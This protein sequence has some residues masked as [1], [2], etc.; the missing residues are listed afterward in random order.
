MSRRVLFLINSL[1]DGG[2]QVQLG[3]IA[4]GL[5]Q[6]GW[7]A[8][9]LSLLTPGSGDAIFQAA[10]IPVRVLGVRRGL[11]APYALRDTIRWI[12]PHR[13]CVLV[14]LL[15]QAH[16]IGR[17]A[18]AIAR[19]PVIS[20]IRNESLGGPFRH[21]LMRLT[22]ALDA[23]TTVN[24]AAAG[25]SLVGRGVAPDGRLRVIHNAVGHGDVADGATRARARQ[26]LAVAPH[27]FVWLAAGRLEPQKD[28]PTL[29]AALDTMELSSMRVM[30]AG[31]GSLEASLRVALERIGAGDRIA[32]LGRRHDVPELLAAADG[33]VLSSAWEGLPNILMEAAAAGR[34]VVSTRVGGVPEIVEDGKTGLLVP[35]RD[36]SA[37]AAAMGRLMA[38]SEQDRQA[39]GAGA[40][41]LVMERFAPARILDLWE[42]LLYEVL[43]SETFPHPAGMTV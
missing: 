31:S 1:E 15:Y 7:D 20:A 38:M 9:V 6:R 22:S 11:A 5:V 26:R 41:A 23:A 28:Y 12:R 27:E 29:L 33:V 39:M 37:L 18:G 19:V 35:P 25:R 3:R 14:T 36:P 17:V 40:R 8:R 32:L 34:P 4:V 10:G 43:A 21:R 30:I 42:D 2:A 16:L 24:S 13:P